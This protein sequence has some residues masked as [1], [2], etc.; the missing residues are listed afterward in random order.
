MIRRQ[1]EITLDLEKSGRSAGHIVT[2]CPVAGGSSIDIHVPV[3]AFVNGPGPTLL[4]TSGIHGDEYE[5]PIALTK[6]VQSLDVSQIKGRLIAVPFVNVRAIQA[7]RRFS[8]D[9]NRDLNRSFP[10]IEQGTP[11]Q[12]LAKAVT[13]LLASAADYV[14][15]LHTGGTKTFW[16]PCAMMHPISNPAMYTATLA[17]IKNM[18]V[19]AAVV[20]DE[21]DKPGMFDTFVESLTKPFVC[22]E[23]GGGMLL[24]EHLAI[25]EIGLRN[26]LRHLR[27]LNGPF[28]MPTWRGRRESRLLEVPNLSYAVSAPAA[29]LVEPLAEIG[30]SVAAGEPI[31]R[32]HSIDGL[33]KMA[34]TVD[35]PVRGVLF[36]RRALA[37]VEPGER[38]AMIAQPLVLQ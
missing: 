26:A 15:D 35:A 16:I 12:L 23:F 27:M 30:D 1:I 22:C 32:I 10:G 37:R 6:L 14:I 28:E 2:R 8:P 3:Y 18:R 4:L 33:D 11:T 36:Q 19:P 31:A 9:D 7:G 5:G 20:I 24:P 25:A 17:L 34:V 38:I 29:G 13:D 21:S